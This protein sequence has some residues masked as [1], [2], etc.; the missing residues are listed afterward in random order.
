M[1]KAIVFTRYGS[2][3]VL[4]LQQVA[5]PVLKDNEIL[6]KV[7]ATT[8]TMG[9]CEI[10][11]SSFPLWLWPLIRLWIGVFKP[12]KKVLGQEVAGEV[13]AVG[14]A[15]KLFKTGDAVFASVGMQLGAYAEYVVLPED[16]EEGILALK[17]DAM[18]YAEAAALS[19]GGLIAYDFLSKAN[20][21]RG[22][23]V[24]INGAGGSIGT[25]AVQIAKAFGAE[26]TSVDSAE[27]L[28]MLQAIG[29]DHV[30]D[31]RQVDF[32]K[33]GQTYDV[34]FDVVGKVSFSRALKSLN[35]NGTYLIGNPAL[36]H[37]LRAGWVSRKGEK[38]VVV[39]STGIPPEA[40]TALKGLIE[41]GKVKT[42]IDRS[43]PLEEIADAHRYVET[44]RKQGNVVVTVG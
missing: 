6:I 10:R 15:V 34:I 42:V 7:H 39:A 25:Y 29:S 16:V 19:V 23:K 26:V 36:S 14:S 9:D 8:V 2:P 21:Q 20:I 38:K 13:E 41:A 11:S 18:S 37:I 33:K 12:R 32:T 24:L 22:E 28:A 30:M 43:Y 5:K 44:G 17:P 35:P 3:D 31:Y 27:K 40:I 1:M 4:Q